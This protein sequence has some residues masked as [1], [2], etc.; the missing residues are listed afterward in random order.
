MKKQNSVL[1][2][3]L[4]ILC[5][6]GFLGMFY[7]QSVFSAQK[8]NSLNGIVA[9]IEVLIS[10]VLVITNRKRGFITAVVFNAL[11]ALY[12]ILFPVLHGNLG[13]LPGAVVSAISILSLAVIYVYLRKNEKTNADLMASY[14]QSIENNR[15][16]QEKDEVLHYLAYYDRL[17]QMPNRHLFMDHLD[18]ASKA[19]SAATVV[20][21]DIDDFR[22]INDTYGHSVGDAILV[23]F[24]E[25]LEKYATEKS[26]VARIGG[27]E[28]GMI[29][30]GNR[31]EAE[32]IAIVEDMRRILSEPVAVNGSN[33]AVTV[34]CGVASFPEDG[35]TTEEIFRGAETAMFAAKEYGKNRTIFY[36][37]RA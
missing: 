20:Y 35:R 18:E 9:Q 34:S 11:N 21:S 33:F 13:A 19:V 31:P 10:T 27:D 4:Y 30:N 17:T 25:R 24:A 16:I 6:V 23:A 37:K 28:F 5:V 3:L 14:E 26:T 22:K 36:S 7:A 8:L 12:I 15:L 29:L 32:V 1:N 2:W